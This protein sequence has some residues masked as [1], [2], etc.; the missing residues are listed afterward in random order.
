MPETE[1]LTPP[2]AVEG[3]NGLLIEVD[4]QIVPN[5]DATIVH[6]SEG[7]VVSGNVVRIDK[8][9]V[10]RRAVDPQVRESRR[11]GRDG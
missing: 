3:S 4:G 11:R 6:F 5:Y 10:L 9:E 1:T 7:D 2:Q 8:D